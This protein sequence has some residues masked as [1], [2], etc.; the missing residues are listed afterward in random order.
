S[1]SGVLQIFGSGTLAGQFTT[2]AGARIELVGGTFTQAAAGL[3][4]IS[5]AGITA[6]TGGTLQLHD[7]IASLQL[8][9]G[10]V[11]LFPDF[12]SAGAITNLTLSGATLAG[13]NVVLGMLTCTSVSGPITVAAGGRVNWVDG[14]VAGPVLVS[15]NGFWIL[16]GA[17]TKSLNGAF[18]NFGTV[19]HQSPAPPYV[20]GTSGGR[21]E[22]V[23]LWDIQGDVATYGISGSPVFHNTGEL[24]KSAG[25]GI[26]NLG[27]AGSY[28]VTL[29][30]A[31]LVSAL[32]GRLQL[33]GGGPLAGQF[34]T[35]ADTQ[36]ELVG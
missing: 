6:F 8:L 7:Q 15:S 35:A 28:P 10:T 3:P 25:A 32:S 9:G 33:F 16:S 19:Q 31:G 26:A 20:Y 21:V 18:T 23:G 34:S 12:Q 24:R 5:G 11:V 14:S 36:I 22:N 17:P 13:T 30:N 27:V 4:T 2:A 29:N 1:Q